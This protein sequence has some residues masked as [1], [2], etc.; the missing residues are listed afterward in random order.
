MR[1][2]AEIEVL[3]NGAV[4]LARYLAARAAGMDPDEAL[5]LA[6]EALHEA[7][8]EFD[9]ERGVKFTT[10]A[11]RRIK[12][13][14]ATARLRAKA[15]KRGGGK[16]ILSLDAPLVAE[17]G[18]ADMSLMTLGEMVPDERE[19]AAPLNL[20]DAGD[21]RRR[22]MA[23]MRSRLT[24]RERLVLQ[25]RYGMAD[26]F[27]RGPEGREQTLQEVGDSLGLTRERIRQVEA[28]ALAKLAK[29]KEIG[30]FRPLYEDKERTLGLT[31]LRMRR[32][33]G[34][35]EVRRSRR[36]YNRRWYE[37]NRERL[38]ERRRK[39]RGG[40]AAKAAGVG[41]GGGGREEMI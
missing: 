40:G 10:Y 27:G 9:E 31:R 17:S 37:K 8:K 33:L 29:L 24:A 34:R 15:E 23:V 39:G 13:R 22:L 41:D 2:H 25:R 1:D 18:G 3:V 14:I 12:W 11:S 36:Q 30:Q 19:N 32:Y 7:A 5:S 21:E 16:V 20:A 6:L 26:D 4:W 38:A 28:V 35:E